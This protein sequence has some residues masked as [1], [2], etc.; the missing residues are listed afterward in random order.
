MN[1]GLQ[2]TSPI[3][4]RDLRRK[5]NLPVMRFTGKH[6]NGKEVPYERVM[7]SPPGNK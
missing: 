4:H 7:D 3:S 2:S 5:E 6:V 1:E